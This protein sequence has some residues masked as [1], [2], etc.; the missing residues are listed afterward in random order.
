[1]NHRCLSLILTLIALLNASNW[2]MEK[3]LQQER[4]CRDLFMTARTNH[5]RREAEVDVIRGCPG[6]APMIAG[7]CHMNTTSTVLRAIVME[8]GDSSSRIYTHFVGNMFTKRDQRQTDWIREN[9]VANRRFVVG[10]ME[11]GNFWGRKHSNWQED[12]T[13]SSFQ[14]LSV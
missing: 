5:P 6:G 12:F 11:S 14:L 8:K 1:M 10:F 7:R 9:A 4:H 2:W 3:P 13:K